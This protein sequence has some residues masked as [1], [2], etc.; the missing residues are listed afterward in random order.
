MDDGS[1]MIGYFDFQ[2][3]LIRSSFHGTKLE[4]LFLKSSTPYDS[5]TPV[6]GGLTIGGILAAVAR[7]VCAAAGS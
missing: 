2:H 7:V 4:G 6:P 3:A 1:F 5:L